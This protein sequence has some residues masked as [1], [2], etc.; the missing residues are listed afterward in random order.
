MELLPAWQIGVP[1][2]P[3]GTQRLV[4]DLSLASSAI[5]PGYLIC[6]TDPAVS[7]GSGS[8]NAG[9]FVGANLPSVTE[10]GGTSV[11]A[12]IFAG[13]VAVLNQVKGYAGG[14][15]LLNPVLYTLASDPAIY[16]AAFHDI[17]EGGNNCTRAICGVGPQTTDYLAGVGYDEASGLG[18]IDFA[19]LSPVRRHSYAHGDG[20]ERKRG[21]R[22]VLRQFDSPRLSG[23]GKQF[24]GCGDESVYASARKQRDHGCLCRNDSVL[25]LNL[26]VGAGIGGIDSE[27]NERYRLAPA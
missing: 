23:H 10:V 5:N 14:Q 20:G 16:A 18:S 22:Y 17:T 27:H 25:A 11:A 21:R 9:F 3:G 19:N 6:S 24:R 26:S 15:G 8:C 2:I 13:L 1:G 4:P 7:E 12:P